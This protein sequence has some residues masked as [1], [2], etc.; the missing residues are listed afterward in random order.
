ML[1]WGIGLTFSYLDAYVLSRQNVVE[2]EW[3]KLK[4]NS[5]K[6]LRFLILYGWAC[7]Q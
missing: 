4:I 7:K 3:E 5:F 6:A 1:G 2:K